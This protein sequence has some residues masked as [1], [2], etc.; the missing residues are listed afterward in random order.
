MSTQRF[1]VIRTA[2]YNGSFSNAAN[3]VQE[4]T[5]EGITYFVRRIAKDTSRS[6]YGITRV[7]VYG[8][9]DGERASNHK[10]LTWAT[11]EAAQ[12]VADKHSTEHTTYAV[13]PLEVVYEANVRAY[14]AEDVAHEVSDAYSGSWVETKGLTVRVLRP[15]KPAKPAKPAERVDEHTPRPARVPEGTNVGITGIQ[16]RAVLVETSNPYLADRLP[17][18][19][20]VRI[21]ETDVDGG[22]QPSGALFMPDVPEGEQ[23]SFVHVADARFEF[24]TRGAR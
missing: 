13:L 11:R 5:P 2:S 18:A 19:G 6:C 22:V 14:R 16:F 12:A 4:P 7:T 15:A 9:I 3:G 23:T 24:S 10:P 21:V 8:V 20:Y 1:A 17:V